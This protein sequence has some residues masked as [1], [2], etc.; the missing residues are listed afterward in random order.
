MLATKAWYWNE[1]ISD[2]VLLTQLGGIEHVSDARPEI[3]TT[4]PMVILTDEN[5]L[6]REFADNRPSAVRQQIKVDIFTKILAGAA[7]T[8]DIGIN[9][10][11][12]FGE[13]F[14]TCTG[15]QETPEPSES[16]RHRVMRFSRDLFP[17]DLI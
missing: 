3:I 2:S 10:A 6:D 13:L 17:S 12:I 14:F 9:V 4:F 5:Q 8:S 16:V 15:N 1:V 7:T 11:R